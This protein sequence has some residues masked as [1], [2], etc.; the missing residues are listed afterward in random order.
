[1]V[2]LGEVRW[3]SGTKKEDLED[4]MG[5]YFEMGYDDVLQHPRTL[6][7]HLLRL[8]HEISLNRFTVK[9]SVWLS[10]KGFKVYLIIEPSKPVQSRR[11]ARIWKDLR[12]WWNNLKSRTGTWRNPTFQLRGSS[13]PVVCVVGHIAWSQN[14]CRNVCIRGL[15]QDLSHLCCKIAPCAHMPPV[16]LNSFD[17]SASAKG[18]NCGMP[19]RV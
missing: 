1:M 15:H 3:G 19:A 16:P 13:E 18:S 12:S 10:L 4:H 6:T 5:I 9:F 14:V 11:R 7:W 2:S 8:E 17:M